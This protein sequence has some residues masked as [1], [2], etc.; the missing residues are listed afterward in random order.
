MTPDRMREH[1]AD[2]LELVIVLGVVV[3]VWTST[4]C[5]AWGV[6]AILVAG[7]H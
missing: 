6:G 1:L 7:L 5:C 3:A 2:A 4:M